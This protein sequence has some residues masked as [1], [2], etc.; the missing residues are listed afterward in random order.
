[1]SG[2]V[3]PGLGQIVLKHL[4]KGSLFIMGIIL[5]IVAF[6][7]EVVRIFLS[8]IEGIGTADP[9]TFPK[10]T[11]VFS[12][13]FLAEEGLVLFASLIFL[14]MVWIVATVDAYWTGRA[15]ERRGKEA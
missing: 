6:S 11:R 8:I 2:L 3:L 15:D 5:G 9:E 13:G 12:Q 7:I 4:W 10:L 14:I 1:M